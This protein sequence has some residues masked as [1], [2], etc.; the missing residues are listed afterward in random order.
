M[1]KDTIRL[2]HLV[3]ME[4]NPCSALKVFTA[5]MIVLEQEIGKNALV[6]NGIYLAVHVLTL[7]ESLV[8]KSNCPV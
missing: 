4:L 5:Q 1:L 7:L 3:I 6:E 2:L 8:F